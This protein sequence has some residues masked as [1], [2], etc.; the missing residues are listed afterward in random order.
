LAIES[1]ADLPDA[2]ANADEPTIVKID[3]GFSLY[4]VDTKMGVE[5]KIR[6]GLV[7]VAV[8]MRRSMRGRA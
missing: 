6:T 8:A 4:D 2:A 1:S 3:A 7:L 5:P